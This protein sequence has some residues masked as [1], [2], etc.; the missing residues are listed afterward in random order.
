[1]DLVGASRQRRKGKPGLAIVAGIDD[2]ERGAVTALGITRELRIE[3]VECPVE[4]HG[5]GP[6]E[7]IDRSVIVRAVFEQKGTRF[8]KTG[9]LEVVPPRRQSPPKSTTVTSRQVL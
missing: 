7:A 5:V 2:P 3:P 9:H 8:L 1:G 4:R 6:A